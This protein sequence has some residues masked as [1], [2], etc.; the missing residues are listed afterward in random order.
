M[1]SL[2]K[3][4]VMDIDITGSKERSRSL[5]DLKSDKPPFYIL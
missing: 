5:E 1:A 3:Y 4:E 2:Y